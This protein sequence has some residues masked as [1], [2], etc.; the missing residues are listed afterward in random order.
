MRQELE[1]RRRGRVDWEEIPGPA[2]SG[3]TGGGARGRV[4]EPESLGG[5]VG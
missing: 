3:R 4:P 1:T 2:R 5:G